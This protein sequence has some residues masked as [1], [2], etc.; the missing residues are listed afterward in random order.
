MREKR[1]MREGRE[2]SRAYTLYKCARQA[3]HRTW[4]SAILSRPQRNRWVP[5]A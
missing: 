5:V 1:Y 4:M 3:S 2:K